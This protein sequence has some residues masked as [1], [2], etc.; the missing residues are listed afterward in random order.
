MNDPPNSASA[1]R[2]SLK[3]IVALPALPAIA[4]ALPPGSRETLN[5]VLLLGISS[6]ALT[7]LTTAL[8]ATPTTLP[9]V[10]AAILGY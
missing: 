10:L 1:T 6:T 4:S 9:S 2:V 5:L 3:E 7:T 8:T